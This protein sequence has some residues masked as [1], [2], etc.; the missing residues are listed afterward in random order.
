M[1]GLLNRITGATL[2]L[3]ASDVTTYVSGYALGLTASLTY[4]NLEAQPFQGN[5]CFLE[6][7]L[8]HEALV[9]SLTGWLVLDKCVTFLLGSFL[10]K[11]GF[12]GR[13]HG[14]EVKEN[15]KQEELRFGFCKEELLK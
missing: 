8:P 12:P 14:F 5:V 2:P 6:L 15:R 10:C 7:P 9:L 4:G 13:H 1:P 11:V 3:T